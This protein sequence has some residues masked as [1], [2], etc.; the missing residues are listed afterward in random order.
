LAFEQFI[1]NHASAFK[2]IARK[3]RGTHDADD[4]KSEAWVIAVEIGKGRGCRLDLSN[5]AEQKQV[6][7]WLYNRCVVFI[8]GK[9]KESLDQESENAPAWHDRLAAPEDS[10]RWRS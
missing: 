4:V 7:A 9:H 3:S 1:R 5:H 2:T 8:R 10:N 6:L